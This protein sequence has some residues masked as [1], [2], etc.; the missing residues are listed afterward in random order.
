MKKIASL[1]LFVACMSLSMS[2]LD[3][4]YF[5]LRLSHP[6]AATPVISFSFKYCDGG[7]RGECPKQF[8]YYNYL[9]NGMIE[10]P[11]EMFGQQRVQYTISCDGYKDKKGSFY[12]G[13]DVNIVET[14]QPLSNCDDYDVFDPDENCLFTIIGLIGH[15]RDNNKKAVKEDLQLLEQCA[16]AGSVLATGALAVYYKGDYG[17]GKMINKKQA[18]HWSAKAIQ[19]GDDACLYYYNKLTGKKGY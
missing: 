2:A 16:N 13:C 4:Y 14:L 9:V 3:T 17:N 18:I 7:F 6:T 12:G 10:F 5:S 19:R 1:F 8:N 11:F 15:I